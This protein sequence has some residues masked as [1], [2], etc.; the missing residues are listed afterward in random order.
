MTAT[1]RPEA[2]SDADNIQQFLNGNKKG[3]LNIFI[4]IP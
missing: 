4:A 2:F 3:Y 1:A